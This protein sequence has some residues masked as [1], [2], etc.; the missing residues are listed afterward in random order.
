MQSLCQY[1]DMFGKPR[2]DSHVTRILVLHVALS[3]VI[4][5]LIGGYFVSQIWCHSLF[6]T[7]ITLFIISIIAHRMFCVRTK[8]DTFLFPDY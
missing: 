2:E 3:D 1:K 6:Y 4:A 5:T 7:I 8:V